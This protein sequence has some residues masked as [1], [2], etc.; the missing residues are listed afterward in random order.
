MDLPRYISG[1]YDTG[2]YTSTIAGK[3]VVNRISGW[4]RIIVTGVE[5]TPIT[6]KIAC[7]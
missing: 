2:G 7:H 3:V 1:S 6:I 5:D 4:L